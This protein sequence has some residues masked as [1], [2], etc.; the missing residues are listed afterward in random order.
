MKGIMVGMRRIRE[1]CQGQ[2]G[3]A[4]NQ[5]G[6][7][8]DRGGNAGNVGGNAGYKGG[9]AGNQGWNE[10]NTGWECRG[11]IKIKGNECIYKNIVLMFSYEKQLKKLI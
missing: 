7:A 3:N 1:E 2:G 8:W 11:G 6:N 9:N 4:R 10:E 5:G